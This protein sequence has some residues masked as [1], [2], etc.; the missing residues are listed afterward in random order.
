M[1]R[2]STEA[3]SASWIIYQNPLDFLVMAQFLGCILV[4][5]IW[6]FLFLH[7]ARQITSKEF[8]NQLSM[9]EGGIGNPRSSLQGDYVMSGFQAIIPFRKGVYN[10]ET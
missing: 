7:K 4:F 1:A 8:E 5:G 6:Y 10:K 9:L 3:Y 2:F